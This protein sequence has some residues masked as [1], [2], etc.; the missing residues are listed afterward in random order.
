MKLS[1]D[2]L[3]GLLPC[4]CSLYDMEYW[5]SQNLPFI[6]Q[7]KEVTIEMSEGSYRPNPIEFSRF[8]LEH[9]CNLKKLVIVHPPNF[10]MPSLN[11]LNESGG[12]L[13]A[14]VVFRTEWI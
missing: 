11:I 13:N 1:V 12:I 8:I 3:V 4:Q 5:K 14:E 7:L 10:A 9:A 2:L 6:S